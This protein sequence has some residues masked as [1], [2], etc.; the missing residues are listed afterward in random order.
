M[1]FAAASRPTP[2]TSTA[3]PPPCIPR[4]VLL[5]RDGVVNADV[6][7]PGVI[8]PRQLQLTSNAGRAIGRLRRRG[9]H[10]SLVTNQ[11]CV[12]KG[13]ISER[14][15]GAI[16]KRLG[17]MLLKED[18]DAMFDNVYICTSTKED[19]D[20][21]MKP[22][23]GMIEEAKHD[24]GNDCT[25]VFIG[26]TLT[27]MMAAEAGGVDLRVLVETGYGRGLMGRKALAPPSYVSELTNEMNADLVQVLPF[28][29]AKDFGN[30]VDWLLGDDAAALF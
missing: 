24:F 26:D 25:C 1:T 3:V 30:A 29:Y 22:E 13:I 7:A 10:V 12:G 14:E 2:A 11:S 5:D 6:G 18:D 16:H 28:I 9:C 17:E 20:R 23:P 21:R 4:L 15:L 19:D 27:D 8:D